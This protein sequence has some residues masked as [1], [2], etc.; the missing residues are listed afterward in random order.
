[1]SWLQ[2]DSLADNSYTNQ[3]NYDSEGKI[4]IM[5]NG[6]ADIDQLIR[7]YQRN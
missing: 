5:D 4:R 2:P 6:P 3:G 7:Q 1:V